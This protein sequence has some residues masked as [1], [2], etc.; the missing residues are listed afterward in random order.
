[1]ILSAISVRIRVTLARK[2][3]IQRRSLQRLAT[4]SW[5]SVHNK[6]GSQMGT[7]E[8]LEPRT[9]CCGARIPTENEN[10]TKKFRP[11][12]PTQN[13]SILPRKENSE[14]EIYGKHGHV[15]ISAVCRNR[16]SKSLFTSIQTRDHSIKTRDQYHSSK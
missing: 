6:T 13:Y 16:N 7:F 4:H 15:V 14:R 3:Q 10:S 5:L 9:F 1:M 2:I 12:I 8:A 11:L